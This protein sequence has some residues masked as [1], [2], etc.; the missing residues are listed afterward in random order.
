MV[1][2]LT[3]R[4]L[5]IA[6]VFVVFIALAPLIKLSTQQLTMTSAPQLLTDPFLQ[7]PAETSVRVVWFTEFEGSRHSVAYG[8]GLS[9]SADAT[10]TK[11]SR[12]REDQK[13][14]V[15]KQTQEGQVYKQP[16]KRDI[17]R[18]EAEVTNLTPGKRVPY[19]VTSVREDG[20]RVSSNQF[21]LAPN[22]TPGTPLKI[23]LTSD[24]QLMPMTAANL[25]KVVET[26]G[27]VDAVFLAGDL[28]NIPDRASEWFDDNRGGAFFPC[29]QGRAHYELEKEGV[30]TTYNGGELIQHAPLFTAIGNH[31]VM[32]R[33]SND[34]SLG[35]QFSDP[36]PRNAAIA[37][38]QKN[39]Q[40][41]NPKNDPNVR[42]AWVKNNSFNIDT[43]NEILTLPRSKTGGKNYYAVSFGDIRLVVLYI[44]NIWR[45]PNLDADARGR[46]RER[47]QDLNN[48]LA[49]GYGQHIF[50]PI[51]EGSSQYNWLK[52]EVNSP[53]F[54]QAKYKI[55]MFHHPPHSLGDNIVPAYTDP[56]QLIGRD[57][58]GRIKAVRYEYPKPADYI[59]RDVVP[60]LEAAGVQLMLYGHSHLWNRFVSPSGMHFLETSN[61]GNTY[62]A[63]IGNKKRPVPKGYLAEYAATGD[64]NG[65]EAVMPTLAPLLG[66][67]NQPLPYIASNDITAFSILDTG[68]G[69]I[70]S[71]H[72]DTRSALRRSASLTPNSEVVKFDEF[73]LAQPIESRKTPR[74]V[75]ELV[76]SVTLLIAVIIIAAGLIGMASQDVTKLPLP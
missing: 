43:Y 25:Q 52:K 58:E 34:S 55:V 31:E 11:L 13:S 74:K 27:R 40:Q 46:Y 18:H 59:I 54:K 24:H 39:A 45:T 61:V 28:V 42:K 23:L 5:L 38:Y 73:R 8:Q 19:R 63:Y 22:P 6:A 29:L 3:S 30:K 12:I 44:T 47:E 10:T 65:L 20:Q 70:S 26:I 69:K 64:P 66:K 32:G 49:W 4:P 71:Y 15:G 41:L 57:A 56:V 7:L 67:D 1:K 36:Y 21:T 50:E 48:P 16:T 37:I 17:W 68:T 2:R 9:R 62:G 53:E 76:A 75:A 60:L 72:F 35:D 33:F 14:K 51:K